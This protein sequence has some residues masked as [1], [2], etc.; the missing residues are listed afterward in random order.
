MAGRE[1]MSEVEG[2]YGVDRGRLDRWIDG[3]R[4]C[5]FEQQRDDGGGCV[6]TREK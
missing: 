3:W 5:G 6:P 2:G 1:L 4:E